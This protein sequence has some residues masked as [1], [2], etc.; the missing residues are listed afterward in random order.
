MESALKNTQS[1][2]PPQ[3]GKGGLLSE[4]KFYSN[5]GQFLQISLF[6]L[7]EHAKLSVFHFFDKKKFWSK[8]P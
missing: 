8:V 2:W 7:A 5:V 1:S 3:F 6:G 4:L